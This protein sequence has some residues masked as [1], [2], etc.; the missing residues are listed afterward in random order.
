MKL[1]AV[2]YIPHTHCQLTYNSTHSNVPE[3]D[4]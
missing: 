2:G 3:D 1:E 4:S